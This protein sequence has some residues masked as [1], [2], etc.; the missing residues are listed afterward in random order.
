MFAQ[1]LNV[2]NE[3]KLPSDVRQPV[4]N[5]VVID[6]R[7]FSDGFFSYYRQHDESKLT[8]MYCFYWFYHN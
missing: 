3:I 2:W 1:E 5:C 6:V 8:T 4:T 7:T